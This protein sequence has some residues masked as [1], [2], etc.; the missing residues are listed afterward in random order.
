MSMTDDLRNSTELTNFICGNCGQGGFTT[1]DG[2]YPTARVSGSETA[3][4]F[5]SHV[6]Q[7]TWQT[8]HCSWCGQTPQTT[9]LSVETTIDGMGHLFCN[10][11]EQDQYLTKQALKRRQI[12]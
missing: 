1:N 11:Q 10:T 7:E 4:V 6:C 12:K 2:T 5:C 9:H 3:L 8:C